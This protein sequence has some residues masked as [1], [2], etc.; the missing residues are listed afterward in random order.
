MC[1]SIIYLKISFWEALSVDFE[2]CYFFDCL[3]TFNF[4]FVR[5]LQA[6]FK[7]R[8]VSRSIWL[9]MLCNIGRNQLLGCSERWFRARFAPPDVKYV[10]KSTSRIINFETLGPRMSPRCPQEVP[11]GRIDPS[12][13]LNVDFDVIFDGNQFR[14][15]VLTRWALYRIFISIALARWAS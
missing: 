7:L 15:I 11:R 3:K 2:Q 8:D 1:Y 13:I 10:F 6:V 5:I 4:M 9:A 12:P 14:S